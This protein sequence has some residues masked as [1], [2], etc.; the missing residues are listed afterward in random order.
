MRKPAPAPCISW[1]ALGFGCPRLRLPSASAA[2]GLGS[3]RPPSVSAACGVGLGLGSPRLPLG[4]PLTCSWLR[5]KRRRFFARATRHHVSCSRVPVPTLPPSRS[6]SP[7]LSLSLFA[8][9]LPFSLALSRVAHRFLFVRIRVNSPSPGIIPVPYGNVLSGPGI[10]P[11]WT[12][13][14]QARGEYSRKGPGYPPQAGT[15]P[16]GR[17]RWF[18]YNVPVPSATS[19][20][21]GNIPSRGGKVITNPH[22]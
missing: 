5:C 18:A 20:P 10:F 6:H 2:L 9:P 16:G 17:E 12:G 21:G 22:A 7:P 4:P 3:P 14:F 19:C 11:P 1:A 8:F 13:T 15:F